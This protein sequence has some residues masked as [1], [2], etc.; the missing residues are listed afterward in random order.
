MARIFVYTDDMTRS[1]EVGYDHY[2]SQ[3]WWA[4]C[5]RCATGPGDDLVADTHERFN[6]Q[7]TIRTAEF[8]LDQC[9]Q[10]V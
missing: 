6:L 5:P 8:H 1:V 2:I 10:G 4:H 7:D 3:A 9:N